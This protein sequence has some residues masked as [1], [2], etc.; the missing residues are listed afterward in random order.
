MPERSATELAYFMDCRNVLGRIDANG[1]NVVSVP[2]SLFLRL[3]FRTFH[4]G[5]TAPCPQRHRPRG[6]G[7]LLHSL[8]LSNNPVIEQ[9]SERRTI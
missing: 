7:R 9:L 5:T 6:G 3:S 2:R 4:L 1:N 8:M